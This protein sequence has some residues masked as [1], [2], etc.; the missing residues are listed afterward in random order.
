VRVQVGHKNSISIEKPQSVF[1]FVRVILLFKM[2]EYS[3]VTVSAP[4]RAAAVERNKYENNES[5]TMLSQ[6]II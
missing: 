3:R 5:F 2:M 1:G 4:W 6:N